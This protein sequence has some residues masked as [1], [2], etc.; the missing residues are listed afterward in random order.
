MANTISEF[1]W[2]HEKLSE[3]MQDF[4]R[5]MLVAAVISDFKEGV[6][7]IENPYGSTAT[8]TTNSPMKGAYTPA[9]FTTTDD[10]LLVDTEEI[11]SVHIRDFEKVFSDFDLG[12]DQ[13]QRA[14]Q[15][16]KEKVDAALL[17]ELATNAGNTVTVAG[18]FTSANVISSVAEASQYFVGYS[19]TLAGTYMV[20]DS[21]S[22]PAF[23][24]AGAS[25][26]F[27]FADS[28]LNNGFYTSFM[29]H[30]IYVVRGL[31]PTDTAIA[32][33]K[34]ASTTGTGGAIKI[35]EKMVS[36]KTGV[37]MAFIMYHTSKLWTNNEDLVVKFDL[38]DAS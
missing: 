3:Y 37:E 6:K 31:L 34:G 1:T 14:A 32:G 21:T 28:V 22:V 27:S 23:I 38:A 19:N 36:G 20:I 13:A 12:L 35:E 16:L 2:T 5:S 7:Y 9:D 30:D 25:N 17:S 4:L 10:E 29:G 15:A 26:G 8:V 18:G 11:Y 33:V 24:V